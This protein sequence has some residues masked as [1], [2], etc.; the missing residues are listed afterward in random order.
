M[1]DNIASKMCMNAANMIS[2][3]GITRD[4]FDGN[5]F[6]KLRTKFPG[7]EHNSIYISLHINRFQLEMNS[8]CHTI[9]IVHLVVHNLDNSIRLK[10]EYEF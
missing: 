4:N 10:F 2:S 1:D 8:S 7:H 6:A 3:N 5:S 9:T